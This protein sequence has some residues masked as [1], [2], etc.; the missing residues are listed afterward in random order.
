M[1]LNLKGKK[2]QKQRKKESMHACPNNLVKNW[3]AGKEFDLLVMYIYV[4]HK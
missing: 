2:K 4:I 1:K 3:P